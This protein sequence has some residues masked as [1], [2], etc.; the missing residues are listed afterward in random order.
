V[1]TVAKGWSRC[2]DRS[3]STQPRV[4]VGASTVFLRQATVV[5]LSNP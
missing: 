2:L 5:Y 3:N 1:P 4:F